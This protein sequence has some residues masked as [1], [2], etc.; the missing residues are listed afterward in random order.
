MNTTHLPPGTAHEHISLFVKAPRMIYL[1]HISSAA[2]LIYLASQAVH[3]PSWFIYLWAGIELIATPF[4]IG[5]LAHSYNKNPDNWPNKRR[6]VSLLD[7]LFLFIGISWGVM[8]FVSLNPASTAHFSMQMAIAA[9]ASAAAVKSLGLFPRTFALYAIPFLG[10]LSARLMILGGDYIMLGILVLI[11]MVMFLGLSKDALLSIQQ[12]IKIKHENLELAEKYKD[13]AMRADNA[14]REKTRLLASASHDL[15]QPAHAIG[16]YLETLSVKDFNKKDQTTLK[17]IGQSL[18]VLTKMFNSVLDVSL[19]D[20]GKITVNKSIVPLHGLVSGIVNDF[21]QMASLVGASIEMQ[22][23]DVNVNCDP[24]LLRRMVQNLIS[25]SI[26]Y[27]EGGNITV[28]AV[29]D[30]NKLRLNVKDMGPG[31]SKKDHGAIFEEFSQINNE[32]KTSPIETKPEQEKGVGLGLSIVKRLAAMQGIKLSMTSDMSGT[33]FSMS[34]IPISSEMAPAKVEVSKRLTGKPFSGKLIMI[35]DD[36]DDSRNATSE[37]LT[38]WGCVTITSNGT[39]DDLADHKPDFIICDYELS[40]GKN[41]INVLNEAVEML[42][43]QVRSVIISGNSS[44]DA[45]NDVASAG[46][47]LISKPVRPAQLR[48]ALLAAFQA[49]I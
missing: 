2:V 46:Q 25:N 36:N 35:I 39:L 47:V 7:G 15:R 18:K 38:H 3:V 40:G 10:L 11:F 33:I 26:R 14:N 24:V 48:S 22:I 30:G 43:Y 31:I 5:W 42:G 4:A 28:Y 37:L 44:V 21:Q 13:A 8:M 17:R 20:A 19:L 27:G 1:G 12:Y 9:G 6:W 32:G 16:L 41:G 23:P 49:E 34:E 29:Q 45:K